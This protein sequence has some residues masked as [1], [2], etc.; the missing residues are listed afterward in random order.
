MQSKKL[1]SPRREFRKDCYSARSLHHEEGRDYGILCGAR[2]ENFQKYLLL[3]D[4]PCLTR[5]ELL[6]VQEPARSLVLGLSFSF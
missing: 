4:E 1:L 2:L 6:S 3:L 5:S